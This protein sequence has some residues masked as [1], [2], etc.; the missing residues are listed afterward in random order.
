MK[1]T[2][3]YCIFSCLL[4]C[5]MVAAFTSCCSKDDDNTV[6]FDRK[7]LAGHW[8]AEIP[9]TGETLNWRTEEEDDMTTYDHVGALIYLHDEFTDFSYWGYIYMKDGDMVNFDG[10]D[11]MNKGS[12]FDYTVTPDGYITPSNY[13]ESAPKVESMHYVDGKIY[14]EVNG[15]QIVFTRP[16]EE[17]NVFLNEFWLMLVEAGMVGYGDNDGIIETDVIDDDAGEPS[18]APKFNSYLDDSY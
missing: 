9:L 17:Q 3:I 15:M 1:K 12:N 6:P 8:Y 2:F 4:C 14:A 13:I 10:I 7:L 5:Y 18:R 16:T 11:R